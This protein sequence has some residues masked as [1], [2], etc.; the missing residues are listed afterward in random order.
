VQES[1]EQNS[2]HNV[3]R[4]GLSPDMIIDLENGRI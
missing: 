4:Q 2:Y 3:Y 1:T